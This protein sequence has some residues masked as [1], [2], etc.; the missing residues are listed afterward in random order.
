MHSHLHITYNSSI[1]HV[2]K[3]CLAP[4]AGLPAGALRR[5]DGSRRTLEKASSIWPIPFCRHAPP[6]ARVRT[7]SASTMG[8]F[9]LHLAAKDDHSGEASSNQIRESIFFVP[10]KEA[11]QNTHQVSRF[12]WRKPS[13]SPGISHIVTRSSLGNFPSTFPKL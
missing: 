8:S 12:C 10:R 9:Q 5:A 1:T 2:G 7:P 11:S 6:R 4:G 13:P 3:R